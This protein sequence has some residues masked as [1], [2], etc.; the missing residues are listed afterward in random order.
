VP[1]RKDST[2]SLL[3]I[4]EAYAQLIEQYPQ[5]R[6]RYRASGRISSKHSEPDN[7]IVLEALADGALAQGTRKRTPPLFAISIAR[8]TNGANAPADFERLA[9][10][11]AG[12]GRPA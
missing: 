4:L 2:P 11:L 1:E 3:T 10:L 5:Y 8:F 12:A 6:A 7:V 9:T